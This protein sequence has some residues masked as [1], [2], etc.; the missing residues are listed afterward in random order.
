MTNLKKIFVLFSLSL[1]LI[2]CSNE[3]QNTGPINPLPDTD[4]ELGGILQ[5]IPID[6]LSQGPTA[7]FVNGLSDETRFTIN[8]TRESGLRTI[9]GISYTAETVRADYQEVNLTGLLALSISA[10]VEFDVNKQISEYMGVNLNTTYNNGFVPFMVIDPAGIPIFGS[11]L[12]LIEIAGHSFQNVYSN[13][14]HP[15]PF[16]SFTKLYY[17][18]DLGIIGYEGIDGEMWALDRYE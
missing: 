5:Q 7:V 17:S 13:Y 1:I 9:H 8:Y 4:L 18:K 15:T 11:T 16:T 12:E 2:R 6:I 3:L 10:K 14:I